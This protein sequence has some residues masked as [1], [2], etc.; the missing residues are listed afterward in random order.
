M[1]RLFENIRADFRAH[2]RRWGAQ[3]FWA[4]SVYRFG[5]WRMGLSPG[6]L[7]K[8]LYP[9]YL[10]A[11]KWIEVCAGI[12]LP[13]EVEIG[14]NFVIDHFGGIIVSGYARFGDDCRIRNGCVV[15]LATVDDP[16]AP[17]IGNNVDIGA[18]AKLLGRIRIGNNVRIGANAVVVDDVPDDSIAVGVPARALPRRSP[19]APTP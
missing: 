7:R 11:Q 4:L 19:A 18:G 6:L 13:C 15:G 1:T 5:R 14:R 16:C 12:E 3:G 2:G 9:I 10:V 17:V 8:A